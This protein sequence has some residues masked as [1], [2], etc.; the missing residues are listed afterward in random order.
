MLAIIQHGLYPALRDE[1]EHHDNQRNNQA[2]PQL[3][4]SPSPQ[5][6]RSSIS[7]NLARSIQVGYA[8]PANG[9]VLLVQ[10][11]IL[12]IMPAPFALRVNAGRYGNP[13]PFQFF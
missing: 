4:I 10:T 8:P 13:F 1:I 3:H 5:A 9:L 2:Y 7:S 6:T 11:Y 12:P